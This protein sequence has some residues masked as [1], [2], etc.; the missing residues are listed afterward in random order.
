MCPEGYVPGEDGSCIFV[1]TEEPATTVPVDPVTPDPAPVT[2][3]PT[4]VPE[5]TPTPEP[6]GGETPPAEENTGG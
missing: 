4:P 3:E 2:P 1:P 6:S 5:P